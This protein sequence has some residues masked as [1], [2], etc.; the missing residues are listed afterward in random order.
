M[1]WLDVNV[2]FGF[3]KYATAT[4]EEDPRD[5]EDVMDVAERLASGAHP[6][7]LLKQA[8]VKN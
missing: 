5:W 2:R 3:V 4:E 6:S 1:P 7:K 8:G